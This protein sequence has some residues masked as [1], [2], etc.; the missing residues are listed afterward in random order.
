[1]LRLNLTF[2]VCNQG[3]SRTDD[4]NVVNLSQEYLYLVLTF[5]TADWN[6]LS[7]Y[8]LFK[9]KTGAYYKKHITDDTVKVPA[10]CLLQDYFLFT[11][12]GLGN[13]DLR[14]TTNQIKVYTGQSGYVNGEGEDDSLDDPTIAEDI[15]LK[16][17]NT[18]EMTVV[19]EDESTATYDVVVR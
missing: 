3:I 17:D 16:L 2:D 10:K 1:M 5:K 4:C 15:Y 7:K 12:Y 18:I 6:G 11:I 9:D 19:F 13:D 8:A 14:V